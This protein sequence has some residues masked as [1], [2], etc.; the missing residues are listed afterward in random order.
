MIHFACSLGFSA[1]IAPSHTSLYRNI[2]PPSQRRNCHTY[3]KYKHTRSVSPH[4]VNDIPSHGTNVALHT[5]PD[6]SQHFVYSPIS[7]F[8][9][10]SSLFLSIFLSLSLPLLFCIFFTVRLYRITI[11]F[12]ALLSLSLGARRKPRAVVAKGKNYANTLTNTRLTQTNPWY[13]LIYFCLSLV[14]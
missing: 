7:L 4:C 8:L 5:A 2:K 10:S 13:H 3:K 1:P 9:A 12:S 14:S 11:C 6:I